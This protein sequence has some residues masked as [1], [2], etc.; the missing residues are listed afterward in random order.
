MTIL[1]SNSSLKIPDSPI[2][3]PTFKDLQFCTKLC[4]KSNSR[5]QISNTA[6]LFS[7]S[8]SK[9]PKQVAFGQNSQERHFWSQIQVF[10]FFCQILQLD[11]ISGADCRYDN[12]F[13]KKTLAPINPKK[14]FF[15]QNLGIFILFPRTL[16][17][18]QIGGCRF[19]T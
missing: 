4:N 11:M 8:S 14:A 3:G 16:A 19:Q 9:I 2:F 13:L 7:N 18:R 1:L 15:V 17:I 6:I 12:S 10:L 5:T